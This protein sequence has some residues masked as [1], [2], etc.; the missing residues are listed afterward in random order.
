M[1]VN[2]FIV[3]PLQIGGIEEELLDQRASAVRMNVLPEVDE[4]ADVVF[5]PLHVLSLSRR[6]S[7][8]RFSSGLRNYRLFIGLERYS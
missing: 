3:A 2:L 1:K 5:E 7:G 6:Q 4:L 8:P